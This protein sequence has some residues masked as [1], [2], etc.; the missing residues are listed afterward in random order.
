MTQDLR[1]PAR[2]ILQAFLRRLGAARPWVSLAILL[3]F[4]LLLGS[5]FFFFPF[6]A[7]RTPLEVLFG[8]LYVLGWA[9]QATVA[10]LALVASWVFLVTTVLTVWHGGA[11]LGDPSGLPLAPRLGGWLYRFRF[12]AALGLAAPTLAAVFVASGEELGGERLDAHLRDLFGRTGALAAGFV[13]AILVLYLAGLLEAWLTPPRR[14]RSGLFPELPLW[15]E[16]LHTLHPPRWQRRALARLRALLR[17]PGFG[18]GYLDRNRQIGRGHALAVGFTFLSATLY[19]GYGIVSCPLWARTPMPALAGVLL[20]VNFLAWTLPALA[21]FL[22]RFRVPV[23]SGIVLLGLLLFQVPGNDHY[24]R[25]VEP[26][27]NAAAPEPRADVEAFGERLV[28]GGPDRPIVIVMAAGGGITSAAWSAK[29]LSELASDEATGEAFVSGLA[30]VSA[31]SGGSVGTMFFVDRL[32]G[33]ARLSPEAAREIRRAASESSLEPVAWGMAF[34]DLLRGVFPWPFVGP[35]W[36]DRSWALEHSWTVRLGEN[37]PVPTLAGWRREALDGR[38]P[39]V[40]FNSTVAE[41]GD[42]F[43]FATMALDR[44]KP[45]DPTASSGEPKP[46]CCDFFAEFHG[47]NLTVPTAVRLSATFPFVSS[48][49]RVQGGAGPGVHFVDGGYYDNS[50]VLSALELLNRVFPGREETL[51]GRPIYLLTLRIFEPD[52]RP[53]AEVSPAGSWA[54]AFLA[55]VSTVIK[56]RTTTQAARNAWEIDQFANRWRGRGLDVRIVDASYD[57]TG[58]LSWRLTEV[59]KERIENHWEKVAERESMK[60]FRRVLAGREPASPSA[61]AAPPPP[62]VAQLE[63][64]ARLAYGFD[65]AWFRSPWTLG[66]ALLATISWAALL[67][68]AWGPL[69]RAFPASVAAWELS[70]SIRRAR[71]LWTGW[72]AGLSEERTRR[73]LRLQLVLDLLFVPF[74]ALL[75]SGLCW[76]TALRFSNEGIAVDLAA[77]AALPLLAGLLDLAEDLFLFATVRRSGP[78]QPW[79]AFAGA[80]ASLK[81]AL[82]AIVAL[83]LLGAWFVA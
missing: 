37:R 43:Q 29:V 73:L 55:P 52:P 21:F 81:F 76:W 31:V 25:L 42:R 11:R 24:F 82:L 50:G 3:R 33:P 27:R 2:G 48:A 69:R 8:N 70:F 51:R 83:G 59:E 20:V 45:A 68:K 10:L 15:I 14:P 44:P 4:Q 49:A 64:W 6:V 61:P 58:P 19:F 40:I 22:D 66:F 72:T 41:T 78:A 30:M 39:L 17:S 57:D 5:V 36:L 79:Q 65:L 35:R 16:T 71:R 26:A 23:L 60:S 47:R 7:R 1:T 63:G 46:R 38:K 54:S 56:V 53:L 34:P 9:G 80:A 12:P 62:A 13:A 77:L 75:A 67:L 74:Y 18:P 28:S 32:D